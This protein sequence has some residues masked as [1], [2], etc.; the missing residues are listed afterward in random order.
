MNAAMALT[1]NE[2]LVAT[3]AGL[4]RHYHLDIDHDE[5]TRRLDNDSGDDAL[6][7]LLT[8]V[9]LRSSRVTIRVAELVATASQLA[10]AVLLDATGTIVGTIEGRG[11]PPW[12][13]VL[14]VH[15]L[16]GHIDTLTTEA[17]VARLGSADATVVVVEAPLVLGASHGHHVSPWQRVLALIE[18]ERRD[19]AVVVI[20]GVLVALLSLATPLA[21]QALVSGI[22]SSALLQPL[23]VVSVVLGVAILAGSILRVLQFTVVELLQRRI[24][25]RLVAD[26]AWRLP[27][28]TVDERNK[29]DTSKIV[30]RFFDVVTAQKTIASLLL[31]GATLILEVAIG[32]V[33]LAVYSPLLL[34]MS[35]SLVLG[36]LF[37]L[38]VLGKGGIES[39]VD[40][41][42]A[43]HD[44]AGWLEELVRHPTAF[45]GAASRD[46]G[47][48]RADAASRAYLSARRRQFRVLLRQ[49]IGGFALQIL[50]SVTLLGLGG[51]LVIDGTLTLGQLMAAELIVTA[52][53]WGLVKLHKQLE[54]AYDLLAAVDKLGHLVELETEREDGAVLAAG[55]L[56]VQA[57]AAAFDDLDDVVN[58]EVA[59][60][61]SVA[62]VDPLLLTGSVLAQTL[63]GLREPTAGRFE[64]GGDDVRDL[65]LV[66]LRQRIHYARQPELFEGTLAE[67]LRV[68][69]A[70]LT[71]RH[72]VDAL[73]LVE[74][75]D[76]LLARADGGLSTLI[77]S[78][79]LKLSP[80]VQRRLMIARAVLGDPSVIVIDGALDGV[81]AA[82][83]RRIAAR[84]AALPSTVVLVTADPSVASVCAQQ[85]VLST[86]TT[87]PTTTTTTT[88]KTKVKP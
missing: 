48:L 67:N 6:E 62:F 5:L 32:L 77:L 79:S 18:L 22:A 7:R 50:A 29:H 82:Q 55:P 60:G 44:V 43:K 14:R 81:E 15:R 36:V 76:E 65:S 47:L 2:A 39:S 41:S 49:A 40:E 70:R 52:V 75:D 33:I 9:G 59:A 72:L 34:V 21:V 61:A 63:Y 68:G 54:S 31:E 3:V 28:L 58:F 20:F 73:A 38:F 11:G 42:Y 27:R 45:R 26:L 85:L 84:V 57:R 51:W 17:L 46:F 13:R 24:F 8:G 86:A 10:P 71:P 69:R 83:A 56:S 87:A 80:T 88:T 35:A 37:I 64:V 4:A 19:V 74:L 23:I 25:V 30:N 1:V 78:G 12:Q 66:A 53:T 16:D